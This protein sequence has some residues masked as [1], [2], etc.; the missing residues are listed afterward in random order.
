MPHREQTS[1][2]E[3]PPPAAPRGWSTSSGNDQSVEQQA[4]DI[5][6]RL[7]REL[8]IEEAL[9]QKLLQRYGLAA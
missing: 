4:T 7:E 3:P 5:L 2:I 9:T 1:V 8:V 6:A